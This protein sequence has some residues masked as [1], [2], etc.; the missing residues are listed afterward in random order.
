MIE[1]EPMKLC[2]RQAFGALQGL[3]GIG[4]KTAGLLCIAVLLSYPWG[5][6]WAKGRRL[7]IVHTNDLH[8]HVSGFGP[9]MDYTPESTDDDATLGGIA[10]IATVIGQLR[11]ERG[12]E[13]LVLDSGDFLMGSLFHTVSRDEAAELRLLK[14]MGYDAVTLGNHEFDLGPHGLASILRAGIFKGGIPAVVAANVS[15]DPADPR[16]DSL[17]AAFLEVPVRPYIILQRGGVKVGIFGLLGKNAAEVAP[18]ARPVRFKAP[19]QVAREVVDLLRRREAVDLVVCLSHGGLSTKGAGEDLDLA[20]KVPGID[21]IVSGHSHTVLREPVQVGATYIVQAGCYGEYV[22][23]LD[24]S[25]GQGRWVLRD[26]R[27]VGVDDSIR[28]DAM[29][30]AEARRL[31][32]LVEER[33]LRP[34]GMSWEEPLASISFPLT[35]DPYA[36]SNLGDFVADAIRF[37]IDLFEAKKGDPGSKVK[38]AMESN[39]LLRDPILPGSRGVLRLPDLFRAFPLGIGPDGEMGYPLL[40]FY[41]TGSEIRK[42]L[43][44]LTTLVP[45]K[46]SDYFLQVS[47]LRFSYNPNRV[48]FD[49]VTAVWLS[50]DDGRFVPLDTSSGNSTLYK[51]GANLYNATF[52]KVIGKFT[53]GILTMVPKDRSG[54]PIEDLVEALVDRDPATPGVQELKEWVA[55]VE[56][57]RNLP[58]KDGDG[59]PEIPVSYSTAQGRIRS[60]P[61]WDL[62]A[63]L[64][65]V[66][67]ITWAALLVTLAVLCLLL[68]LLRVC[69][70]AVRGGFETRKKQPTPA[71]GH[72]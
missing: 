52:L 70:R 10:R 2:L 26:Y 40:S 62:S 25:R 1:A 48:P 67:W 24:L 13:V 47:G 35:W 4:I 68:T 6:A 64:N 60:E 61:T 45:M 17:E 53:K 7:T 23:V 33:F 27:L 54:R 29:M 44:V 63:L 3:G 19:A 69:V 9:E 14:F 42:A 22:G 30:R 15:F 12:D 16:D 72:R 50:L 55:L 56:Y 43:E 36:E 28:G 31:A 11:R 38:V 59:L 46:G 51:V 32:S 18:F 49:R 58:D 39:G 34:K 57:V 20:R 8:S 5:E 71:R 21:V 37:S 66:T 41:L 65:N